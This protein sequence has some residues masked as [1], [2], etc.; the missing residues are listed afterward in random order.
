WLLSKNFTK[1]RSNHCAA[2]GLYEDMEWSAT[3][4]LIIQRLIDERRMAKR[5]NH[6]GKARRN[7]IVRK[8]GMALAAG[9][10]SYNQAS[11]DPP[12]SFGGSGV[13]KSA[14]WSS[15]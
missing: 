14:A 3:N 7:C 5:F 6:S 2:N 11:I 1:L 8:Q 13:S 4:H 9:R 15:A 12:L 10:C